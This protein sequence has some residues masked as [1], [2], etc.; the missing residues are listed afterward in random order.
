MT[1]KQNFTLT[2]LLLCWAS[3]LSCG[4]IDTTSAAPAKAKQAIIGY[5][6]DW[7]AGD[8]P[9]NAIPYDKLTHVYYVNL[10][11]T[12]YILF[13]IPTAFA[14][15]QDSND[16]TIQSTD[17]TLQQIVSLAHAAR[18]K[19]ILT[20][21]GWTGSYTFS[22]IAAA[23]DRRQQFVTNALNF[24]D[25]FD[26]DGIDIDWEYPGAEGNTNDFDA[27]SDA[28]N[29]LLLLTALRQALDAKYIGSNRKEISAATDIEPFSKNGSPLKD[30]SAFV[31]ILDR[32]GSWSSTT[33]PNSPLNPSPEN[34][35]AI[36]HAVQ[37]WSSAGMPA[38]KIIIGIAFYGR[39][40]QASQ[41]MD[42]RTQYV[43]FVS[44]SSVEWQ[45]KDL[46]SQG[47]LSGPTKAAVPWVRYFD[48]TAGTP[49]LYNTQT[50]DFISYDDPQSLKLKG[51]YIKQN[52]LGGCMIWDLAQDTSS[53]ELLHAL[54]KGLKA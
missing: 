8:Y 34:P 29:F 2:I 45:W 3:I 43:P 11:H 19:V 16:W 51:Q 10:H 41:P 28:D 17:S 4:F 47:I 31:P 39:G 25:Q 15:P 23:P 35:L 18:T 1:F 46:R 21:G 9:P 12:P 7:S 32:Y 5:Y 13:S 14:I 30:V 48:K 20:F 38:S 54:R 50:Q 52:A 40:A 26:L 36:T 6:P 27:A 33:G 42:G 37:S 24:I 22:S 49:W 53:S 44:G